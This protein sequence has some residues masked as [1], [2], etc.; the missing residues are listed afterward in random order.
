MRKPLRRLCCNPGRKHVSLD[1][2]GRGGSEIKL[3]SECI[4]P[5]DL[6]GRSHALHVKM[7]DRKKNPVY[8]SRIHFVVDYIFKKANI[9]IFPCM[10]F[11]PE[12]ATPHQEVASVS[13]PLKTGWTFVTALTIRLCRSDTCDFLG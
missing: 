3:A 7:R 4:L 6:Q 1:S 5:P 2:K 9:R 13:F 8:T 10:L 12:L 11:H